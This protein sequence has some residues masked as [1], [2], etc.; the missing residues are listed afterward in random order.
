[1][2]NVTVD[3]TT[4]IHVNITISGTNLK[5]GVN[6]LGIGNVTWASNKSFGNGSNM[7]YSNGRELFLTTDL[8][9]SVGQSVGPGNSTFFRFWV[10]IPSGQ[11]AGNYNG[12][13][14]MTCTDV[15]S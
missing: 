10:D 8:V 6:T 12:S 9:Q 2:Y 14:T 1:M 4:N 11:I 13:Y 5:Y 3:T 7:N 15:D